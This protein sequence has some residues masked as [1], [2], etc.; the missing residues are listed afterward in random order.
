MVIYKR[1][2]SKMYIFFTFMKMLIIMDGPLASYDAR[3]TSKSSA[4]HLL[5]FY[6]I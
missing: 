2:G 3:D 6:V 4:L 1:W 5:F